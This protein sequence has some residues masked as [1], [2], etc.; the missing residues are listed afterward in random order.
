MTL[1]DLAERM[2]PK[3]KRQNISKKLC[4]DNLTEDDLNR[5]AKACD[6]TFEGCFTLND[7]GKIL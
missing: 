6:A 2:E 1:T 7:T 4:R 5:I 3:T